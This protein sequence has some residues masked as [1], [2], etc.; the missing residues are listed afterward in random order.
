VLQKIKSVQK[1]AKIEFTTEPSIPY[2]QEVG[3]FYV[4]ID[5]KTY[6][7]ITAGKINKN[8]LKPSDRYALIGSG[9]RLV[10]LGVKNDGFIPEE[11]Y[12][13]FLYCSLKKP[14]FEN[15]DNSVA[16]LRID[17]ASANHIYV[18]DFKVGYESYLLPEEL[19]ERGKTII[20]IHLYKGNYENPL[21]LIGGDRELSFD[22]VEIVDVKDDSMMLK[23]IRVCSDFCVIQ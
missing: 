15:N 2:P 4:K 22:E 6:D 21:V 1:A 18:A 23:M 20:S 10:P 16:V 13:G 9:K 12:D 3:P 19:K 11:A 14:D 5:Q 17:P 8:K 7:R